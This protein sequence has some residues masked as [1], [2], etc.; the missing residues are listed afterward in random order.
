MFRN[1]CI[2]GSLWV[3][4]LL[5]IVLQLRQQSWFFTSLHNVFNPDHRITKSISWNYWLNC[6]RPAVRLRLFCEPLS[7]SYFWNCDQILQ[8]V[9]RI[10]IPVCWACRNSAWDISYLQFNYGPKRSQVTY[11]FDF[12]YFPLDLLFYNTERG[13]FVTFRLAI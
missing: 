3:L 4:T 7:I 6:R 2:P 5:N 10:Y 8:G 12:H 9:I 1:F 13:T 11:D